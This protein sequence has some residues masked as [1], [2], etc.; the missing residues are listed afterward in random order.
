MSSSP[1]ARTAAL[2]AVFV[3][4]VPIGFQAGAIWSFFAEETIRLGSHHLSYRAF[5]VPWSRH[6]VAI[7]AGLVGLF[8]VVA[9]LRLA[10]IES[11]FVSAEKAPAD[12]PPT[13]RAGSSIGR[14]ADS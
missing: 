7:A 10:V 8:W 3:V 5:G 11:G 14:A 9:L 2:I 6:P 4:L 13:F 12:P 1:V